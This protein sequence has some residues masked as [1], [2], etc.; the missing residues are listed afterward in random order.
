MAELKLEKVS[1][2]DPVVSWLAVAQSSGAEDQIT[3]IRVRKNAGKTDLQT[4]RRL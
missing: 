1:S 2:N 4:G 3:G